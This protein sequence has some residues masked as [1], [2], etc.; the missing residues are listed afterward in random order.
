MKKGVKISIISVA[1]L[2]VVGAS[3]FVLSGAGKT[4]AP[5]ASSAV[6]KAASSAVSTN[7]TGTSGLA[8]NGQVINKASSEWSTANAKAAEEAKYGTLYGTDSNELNYRKACIDVEGKTLA[9]TNEEIK[10]AY[11]EGVLKNTGSTSSKSS[12]SGGST[13][14]SSK[15]SGTTTGGSTSSKSSGSTS[16]KST[17]G[18]S[19]GGTQFGQ[20]TEAEKKLIAETGGNTGAGDQTYNGTFASPGGAADMPLG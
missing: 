6:K 10:Q 8:A 20:E 19:T 7:G 12:T 3:V 11:D 4:N 14:T 9:Q 2:A 1:V 18:G 15:S 5:A 13:G 17:T 16:S